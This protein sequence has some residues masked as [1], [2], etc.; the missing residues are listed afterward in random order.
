MLD[1]SASFKSADLNNAEVLCSFV[2]G[3]GQWNNQTLTLKL[4]GI[5][6]LFWPDHMSCTSSA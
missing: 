2:D 5:V 3:Y 1:M 6:E 4:R